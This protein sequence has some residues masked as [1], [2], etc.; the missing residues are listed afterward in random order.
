MPTLEIL[1][2]VLI[3][4]TT[5]IWTLLSIVLYKTIKILNTLQ[6]IIEIYNKVKQIIDIYSQ[7]PE[8]LFTYV[9]NLIF[10]EKK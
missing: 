2:I 10:W 6:E 8:I 4:F 5:V 9:K 3:I 1:Y 7:I